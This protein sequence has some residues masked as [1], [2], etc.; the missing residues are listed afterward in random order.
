VWVVEVDMVGLQDEET[1]EVSI[2]WEMTEEVDVV[3][4]LEVTVGV[5]LCY[6]MVTDSVPVSMCLFASKSEC[7]Q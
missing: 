7:L 6:V 5:G 1:G 3:V 4:V 2:Q